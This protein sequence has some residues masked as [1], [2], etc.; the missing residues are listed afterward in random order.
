M[1]YYSTDTDT[2][3][4]ALNDIEDNYRT[5]YASTYLWDMVASAVDQCL[6][7][8]TADIIREWT[9]AGGNDPQDIQPA[10]DASITERM[11]FA[12]Y[13]SAEADVRANLTEC[14]IDAA[15]WLWERITE[16]SATDNAADE[17]WEDKRTEL[18]IT[19][20]PANWADEEAAHDA[21][22]AAAEF[23]EASIK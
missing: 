13:E 6:P 15:E 17:D 10:P 8:Y 21:L 1:S 23:L 16:L 11:T 4:R 7:I 19:L 2:A 9:D 22:L 3:R 20:D 18:S 12:L 14:Q 5:G